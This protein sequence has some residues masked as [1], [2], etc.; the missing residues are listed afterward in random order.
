MPDRAPEA[1]SIGFFCRPA[2]R[3]HTMAFARNI[4]F[5]E[6]PCYIV[7]KTFRWKKGKMKKPVFCLIIVGFVVT[8]AW[9]QSIGV[10]GYYGAMYGGSGFENKSIFMGKTI[11]AFSQTHMNGTFLGGGGF[12]FFDIDYLEASVGVCSDSISREM[13]VNSPVIQPEKTIDLNF[14]ALSLGL[15]GKYTF[16]KP[17]K[18][19]SI[20]PIKFFVQLGAEYNLVLLAK[21]NGKE[22]GNPLDWSHLWVKAGFGFDFFVKKTPLFFRFEFLAGLLLPSQAEIDAADNAKRRFEKFFH[23]E[24][25]TAQ[26]FSGKNFPGWGTTVR[27]AVGYKL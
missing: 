14:T 2:A 27:L 26:S 7:S 13:W 9:G 18:L 16:S 23:E 19:F 22:A 6:K 25:G 3:R 1:D 15:M 5:T 12:V 21:L 11:Q 10:G 24:Y 17:I 20:D 8:A 4:E